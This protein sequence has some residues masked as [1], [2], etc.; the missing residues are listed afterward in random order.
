M[1]SAQRH[2][3]ASP[4]SAVF[5]YGTLQRGEERE[6]GWPRPPRSIHRATVR[7]RV[8]DLGEYP[9]LLSGTERVGGELW[10]LAPHDMPATLCALDR[11][12]G[13]DQG[14]DNN[15][16]VRRVVSCHVETGETVSAYTY[17]LAQPAL[18][19]GAP[20]VAAGP[21]GIRVWSRGTAEHRSSPHELP[22]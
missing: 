19:N 12:E 8:F 9:A 7:G 2:Q 10:R 17:F 20:E 13:Y 3:H 16:Y 22:G 21:D 18:T 6:G 15:L 5:V 1:S 4:P 14:S 11:I